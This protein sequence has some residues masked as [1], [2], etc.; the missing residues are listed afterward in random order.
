MNEVMN[1]MLDLRDVG[2]DIVTIG[3]YLQPSK[4]HLEVKE[5]VDPKIFEEY[6]RMGEEMGFGFVASS[7]YVRSSYNASAF[8]ERFIERHVC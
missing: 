5:Y 2:C 3:Q 1:V 7:P 4:D 6:K 8:S